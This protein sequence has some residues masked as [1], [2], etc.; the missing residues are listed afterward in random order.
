[1]S[2]ILL[3]LSMVLL[4]ASAWFVY[5]QGIL[6]QVFN[7]TAVVLRASQ[8]IPESYRVQPSM[9]TVVE[10]PVSD[11]P[12]GAIAFP[13]G[14]AEE[15]V[16]AVLTSGRALAPI[17][18]QEVLSGGNFGRSPD[19]WQLRTMAA[20]APGDP[21]ETSDVE[22][23]LS[24][25]P[26]TDGLRFATREEADA[27]VQS[28]AGMRAVVALEPGSVLKLD[29]ITSGDGGLVYALETLV[30]LSSGATLNAADVRAVTVPGTEIPRGAIAF[31]SRAGADIFVTAS[32]S[33]AL[34]ADV[35]AGTVLDATMLRPGAR[36]VL[37]DGLDPAAPPP[38]TLAELLEAQVQ[39]PFGV[40][41][42]NVAANN[43]DLTVDPAIPLVGAAPMENDT[44]DLWVETGTTQG[45]Y[46]TISLRRFVTGIRIQKVVD[47]ELV[48]AQMQRQ[49]AE[50]AEE[51]SGATPPD[52]T[53]PAPDARGIFYW[54]NI[55]RAGGL[56]V[57]EAKEDGRLIFAMSSRTPVSDFLGNGVLCRD[58]M[59]TVSVN[60][61]DNLSH[62]REAVARFQSQ[63]QTTMV[64]EVAPAPFSVLDGVSTEIETRMHAEGYTTFEDVARW[65]D[66][67]LQLIEF[68]LGISRTLVLYIREQART[69]VNMPTAARQ[70]LS[71]A[72]T[73]TE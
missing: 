59:C 40:K 34:A 56:A 68:E 33:L 55:T 4:M 2:R 41:M 26:T 30:A 71:I 6:G 22:A 28:R 24:D 70:Q 48:L 42:I 25:T 11:L 10:I 23:L 63:E 45:T 19:V 1:M 7:P 32:Q 15:A 20:F 64:E 54:A 61:S 73:P 8:D 49:E 57:E 65:E 14:V 52:T 44:M 12:A 38:A 21:V 5:S 43:P 72:A 37:R 16:G 9:V 46:G 31:P 35:P 67:Q 29:D 69:I 51:Q 17:A 36:R 39:E 50:L 53:E 62:V 27:F 18:N 13:R 58:D 66:A 47:P 3:L 60:A